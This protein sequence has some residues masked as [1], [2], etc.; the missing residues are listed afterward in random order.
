MTCVAYHIAYQSPMMPI[1]RNI[2]FQ[3]MACHHSQLMHK[4][5]IYVIVPNGKCQARVQCVI[6]EEKS[7]QP[8]HGGDQVM[9]QFLGCCCKQEGPFCIASIVECLCPH[10]GNSKSTDIKPSNN[11]VI[12]VSRV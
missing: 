1:M 4:G 6:Q 11:D 2:S 9:V 7:C 3:C 10:H 12:S 5:R 8:T